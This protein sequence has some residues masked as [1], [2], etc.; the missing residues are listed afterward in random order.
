MKSTLFLCCTGLTNKVLQKP[1]N[2]LIQAW[3]TKPKLVTASFRLDT[4]SVRIQRYIQVVNASLHFFYCPQQVVVADGIERPLRDILIM[5]CH[6]LVPGSGFPHLKK[7][8]W[9]T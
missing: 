5:F 8:L 9:Q 6:S 3:F 2:I 4:H 1:I 7:T